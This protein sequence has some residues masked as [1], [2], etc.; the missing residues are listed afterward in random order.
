MTTTTR[1]PKRERY[2]LDARRWAELV[3]FVSN[4]HHITNTINMT[5][6]YERKRLRLHRNETTGVIELDVIEAY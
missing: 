4:D 6:G 5:V 3:E 2:A 1:L